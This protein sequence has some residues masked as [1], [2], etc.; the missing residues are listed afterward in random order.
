MAN[1]EEE[2]RQTHRALVAIG[3]RMAEKGWCQQLIDREKSVRIVLT[4]KGTEG[5]KNILKALADLDPSTMEDK[6]YAGLILYLL[7][8]NYSSDSL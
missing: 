8:R 1:E 7:S 6:H 5:M 4:P 2:W 3:D